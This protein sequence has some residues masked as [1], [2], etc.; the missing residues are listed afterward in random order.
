MIRFAFTLLAAL[1]M[2]AALT[3]W[4][5]PVE[6]TAVDPPS[7]AGDAGAGMEEPQAPPPRVA[8]DTGP[9]ES[10]SQETQGTV[11]SEATPLAD[12]VAPA[13]AQGP[14]ASPQL[15]AMRSAAPEPPAAAPEMARPTLEEEPVEIVSRPDFAVSAAARE[16]EGERI[17]SAGDRRD[18]P[19]EPVDVDR[20]GDLIRRMLALYRSMSE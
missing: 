3:L 12:A 15:P 19:P 5:R 6:H 8:S 9:A 1:G 11:A 4:W 20:S 18:A 16:P 10:G 17:A 2:V 13:P 7:V 14:P